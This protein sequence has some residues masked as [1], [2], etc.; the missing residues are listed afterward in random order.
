MKMK[1]LNS[2]IIRIIL[3]ILVILLFP[4][5]NIYKDGGTKTYTSLTYKIIVWNHFNEPD[6]IKTGTE[7][8]FFPSNFHNLDYYLQ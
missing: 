4:I 1:K 3:I 5:P 6:V 8:Y 7:V 2:R